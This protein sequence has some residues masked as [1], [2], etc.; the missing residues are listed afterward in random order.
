[1]QPKTGVLHTIFAKVFAAALIAAAAMLAA[2]A[3]NIPAHA[4][5]DGSA[6]TV[7]WYVNGVLDKTT[8]VKEGE[9]PVYGGSVD[10]GIT[11]VE[12]AGWAAAPNSGA[13]MDEASLPAVTANVSYYASFTS[14]TFFY[15]VLEGRQNTSG[16][17]KDYMYAGSGT[18]LVPDGFTQSSRWYCGGTYDGSEFNINDYILAS[19][20][21]S[22][23]RTG[24]AAAYPGYDESWS[25]RIDWLTLSFAFNSTGYDYST[26]DSAVHTHFDGSVC[27]DTGTSSGIMYKLLMPDGSVLAQS[28]SHSKN[29]SY[30]LNSTVSQTDSFITDSFTYDG[31]KS[32][33]G[34]VYHFDG[35]YTDPGYTKKAPGENTVTGVSVYY[36]RYTTKYTITFLD[37]DGSVISSLDTYSYGDAAIL[38]EDP[39]RDQDAEYSY[40]FSGWSPDVTQPVAADAVYTAV[41]TADKLPAE[42]PSAEKPAD[43]GNSGTV[44]EVPDDI[45]DNGDTVSIAETDSTD[46]ESILIHDKPRVTVTMISQG[47]GASGSSSVISGESGDAGSEIAALS[48]EISSAVHHRRCILHILLLLT[49]AVLFIL[50]FIRDLRERRRLRELKRNLY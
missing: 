6:Y 41:Y 24:L 28:A 34:L 39:A 11:N 30:P 42:K 44:A 49:A 16:D 13:F 33:N 9:L 12:F 46:P 47:K 31:L 21:D 23:I 7:S 50:F 40:S 29:T 38:P 37:Y 4:R 32:V 26:I 18:I 3:F 14:K 10:R 36:A 43:S 17:P 1:M 45:P 27:V 8:E 25:Y 5:E 22:D 15:M 19:P 35:W 2:A 20:S 48:G